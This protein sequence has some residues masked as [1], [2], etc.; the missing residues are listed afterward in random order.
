MIVAGVVSKTK[1]MVLPAV[2][3]GPRGSRV[4]GRA[5]VID[6]WSKEVPEAGDRYEFGARSAVAPKK[7]KRRVSWFGVSKC[8]GRRPLW[9][10]RKCYVRERWGGNPQ[11]SLIGAVNRL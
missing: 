6:T 10:G 1:I 3:E 11:M 4:W 7:K 2:G 9:W 8:L 5:D